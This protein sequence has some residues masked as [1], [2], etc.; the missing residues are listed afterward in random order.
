MDF[1]V[2][3]ITAVSEATQVSTGFKLHL[4]NRD[5]GI[6][7]PPEGCMHCLWVS[8]IEVLN[9]FPSNQGVCLNCEM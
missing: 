7:V 3:C 6:C 5:S 9:A 1:V 8:G 4:I 2:T